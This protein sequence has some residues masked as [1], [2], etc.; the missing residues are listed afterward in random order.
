MKTFKYILSALLILGTLTSCEKWFD[1]APE[2]EMVFGDFWKKK[3]D[4]LSSVGSCY[5]GLLEEGVIKRLIVW[6]EVRS[7]NVIPGKST[8]DNLSYILSARYCCNSFS[9]KSGSSS[10]T[11][12]A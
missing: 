6:G 10:R 9:E 5:R 4:V 2:S 3:T 1:Q 11:P 12:G 7:D 8:E